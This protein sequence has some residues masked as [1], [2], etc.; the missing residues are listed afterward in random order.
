MNM[1]KRTKQ[2]NCGS[3]IAF[4]GGIDTQL[5]IHHDDN[6][7]ARFLGRACNSMQA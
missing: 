7:S 3:I 5:R 4:D 2:R 6:Y 1:E